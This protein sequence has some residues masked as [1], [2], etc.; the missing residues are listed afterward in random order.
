VTVDLGAKRHDSHPKSAESF[1]LS[2]DISGSLDAIWLIGC[3]IYST[4]VRPIVRIRTEIVRFRAGIVEY[5]A[6]IVWFRGLIVPNRAKACDIGEWRQMRE[7]LADPGNAEFAVAVL[8]NFLVCHLII[9]PIIMV[10]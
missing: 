10:A 3:D 5:R 2:N 6:G 8:C 9:A 1:A 4:S 7:P